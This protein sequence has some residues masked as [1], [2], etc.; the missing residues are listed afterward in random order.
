MAVKGK[1]IAIGVAA[2]GALGAA[3]YF[4]MKNG[5]EPPEPPPENLATLWGIVTDAGTG[6]RLAGIE[7]TCSGYFAITDGNGR[8]EI[9]EILPGTYLVTF[10]DPTGEY[11]SK[12]V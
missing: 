9:I 4:F 6:A 1:N 10:T 5:E 2:A 3:I 12:E 7:V 8:Y 11:G